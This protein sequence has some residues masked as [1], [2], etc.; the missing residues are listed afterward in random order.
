MRKRDLIYRILEAHAEGSTAIVSEPA[1]AYGPARDSQ[2]NSDHGTSSV[3]EYAR[4][5][6]PKQVPLKGMLRKE[7]VLAILPDGYG[8]LR[9]AEYHYQSSPDDIYVSPSQI[10]RFA[11]RA[12]DTVEGEIRPPREGQRF[13]ALIRV[14]TIN[15]RRPEEMSDRIG[16]DFL[17]PSYPDQRLVLETDADEHI[18]RLVDL[19]APIGLGQRGLVVAPPGS[20]K[21]QLLEQLATASKL[22]RPDA[23]VLHLM[24]GA[25]P[26]DVARVEGRGP[27]EAIATTFD[28]PAEQHIQISDLVFEKAKR[29]VEAGRDVVILLDSLTNLVRAHDAVYGGG[30]AGTGVVDNSATRGPRQLFG[31]ARSVEEGGTLTV[32]AVADLQPNNVFDRAVFEEFQGASNF[33]IVLLPVTATPRDIPAIDVQESCT[34]H[35]EMLYS[36]DAWSSIQAL[37]S[38]V[39]NRPSDEAYAE[40][41]SRLE[42][43]QTNAVLLG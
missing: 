19:V 37:R 11:L 30:L 15:G 34:K 29:A 3:P 16:F 10:K 14:D 36:P 32:I 2:R 20:R 9:S 41:I 18:G 5:F 12:S 25:R 35:G 7:G 24:I 13:F 42:V 31:A 17:T 43:S 1:V 40:I 27:V 22:N 8:F 23:L 26:E 21:E 33:D 4:N 28:A 6:D 38:S 39:V